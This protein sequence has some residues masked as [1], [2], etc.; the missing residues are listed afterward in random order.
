MSESFFTTKIFYR[1][2]F[3]AVFSSACLGIANLADALCVGIALGEPALAAISLVSPIYMVFNVLDVGIALGGALFFTRLMG[4]GRAKQAVNVFYQ[5]LM[6]AA[7]V[8]AA[9]AALGCAFVDGALA[10]LGAFPSQG[11]IY[12]L[13]REYALW[14]MAAAP[15]FFFSQLFYHFIRC[16]DGEKRAGAGLAVTTLLDVG[17]SFALVL[18]LGMGVKGAIL[19]PS[20][21]SLPASWSICPI[22]S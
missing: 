10:I 19:P 21:E 22:F 4:E 8:S 5:M 7:V 14:L 6:A 12:G 2:F 11:A 3:P 16:D 1:F 13:T 20:W 15:L 18:G 17:L 9:L